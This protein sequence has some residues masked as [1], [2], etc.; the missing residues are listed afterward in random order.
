[1]DAAP[2]AW[3]KRWPGD[4]V[5]AR[6]ETDAMV[7]VLRKL[8][9]PTV[10]L[11][12]ARRL[13]GIPWIETDDKRVVALALEHLQQRGFTQ[14]AYCGFTGAN[15]SLRRK[16]FLIELLAPQRREVACYESPGPSHP[17]TVGVELEGMLDERG[18]ADW[19][20][21]LPKPIGLLA[22]NDIRAQQVLI[23]CQNAEIAVPDDV[24]VIGIDND[25]VICPL[26]DPPLTSVEP[27][28]RRIGFE[29]AQLL[30]AMMDGAAPPEEPVF[31][32][33]RGV[34][35]RR[36]TDVAAVADRELAAALRYIRE[37]ACEGINVADVVATTRMSRRSLERRCRQHFQKSPH[38]LIAE[39]KM[40]RLRDLLT[41]TELTLE[42]LAPLAGFNHVEHLSAFF[43][44]HEA[45]S[46]GHYRATAGRR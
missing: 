46:P 40:A 7:R 21:S 3:L 16:Q 43:K 12:C 29:A 28:T 9:L 38:D 37:Y 4:G 6:I 19:L 11:R 14:F 26:C 44:Q 15:Y 24:A 18:V 34:V 32:P 39:V 22:S 20:R 33:P 36:S 1:M 41:R 17:T 35:E 2:P 5:I 8:K 31:I 23:A 25:D 42:Q 30:D 45:C 10:D 13:P 27:D